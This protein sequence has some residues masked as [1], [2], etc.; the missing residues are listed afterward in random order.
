[1]SIV[2]D[3][4]EDFLKNFYIQNFTN[5]RN[6]SDFQCRICVVMK[7][8]KLCQIFINDFIKINTREIEV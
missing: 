5:E 1:M 3:E 8:L 2:S 7:D 4:I 6:I